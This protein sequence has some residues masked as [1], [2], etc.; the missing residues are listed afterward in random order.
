MAA[1]GSWIGTGAGTGGELNKHGE[2]GEAAVGKYGAGKAAA[3][4]ANCIWLMSGETVTLN[5][6]KKSTPRM[7][8]ATAA[9]K[10]L[11][12][13]SLPWNF[14]VFLMKPQEGIGCPSAPLRRG[15]DGLEF[16]LQGTMLK[17][18]PVSTRYL[19]F[20]NS[21][22]N[23]PTAKRTYTSAEKLFFSEVQKCI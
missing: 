15:P 8:P 9:C 18:A 16:L 5:F 12:V 3:V 13:K 20:V 19:S 23:P 10:K 1:A 11:D 22:V 6:L 4:Q 14:T 21:S 2:V 17:V 7:G